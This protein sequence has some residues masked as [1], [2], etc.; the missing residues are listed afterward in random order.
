MTSDSTMT[1]TIRKATG[2][3]IA[4]GILLIILGFLAI[5]M[6]LAATLAASLMFGWLFI[7]AGIAQIVFA[8]QSRHERYFI[9]KL[10][11]GFV[12]ILAGIFVLSSPIITA[13]TLTL[14]MGVS[15]FIESVIQVI[16][17][18]QMKPERGWGWILFSGMMGIVLAIFIGSQWPSSAL[19]FIGIWLG[20]NFLSD[21]LGLVM[22]SSAVRSTL[23][24]SPPGT[25][26]L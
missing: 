21:G 17:A 7:V 9:W 3:G 1:Q 26:E 20:V 22:K 12:Y 8:F 25:E 24:E 11:L 15:I 4:V 5:V 10:L 13:L 19:W 14:I 6:P 23:P 16:G 2:W 18:F